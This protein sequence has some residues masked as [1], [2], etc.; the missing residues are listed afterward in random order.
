MPSSAEARALEDEIA[1][2]ICIRCDSKPRVPYREGVFVIACNCP[3]GPRLAKPGSE[4]ED[5]RGRMVAHHMEQDGH[6][7]DTALARRDRADLTAAAPPAMTVAEFHQRQGLIKAVVAEMEE[8]IHYGLIPGTHDKSLWE[9]GAE[10]LRAAFRIDWTFDITLAMEDRETHEYLYKVITRAI[11][12][13]G[14]T[15]AQ[16]AAQA[17]SKERRFWCKSECPKPCPQN[18]PPLGMEAEMMPHNVQD[19]SIKRGFVA[20]I[21]NVTGTTGYFKMALDE[22]ER[23]NS[24]PRATAS[25][26]YRCPEHDTDWFKKGKMRGYAHKLPDNT[27][28]NMPENGNGKAAEAAT[29]GTPTLNNP[30]DLLN[31]ALKRF[32]KESK[33]VCAALNVKEP[34]D[35]TDLRTA[36][37][38]LEMLWS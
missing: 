10:Y 14:Q 31:A 19:R 28:C 7:M 3:E 26:V 13:D 16:W 24:S 32:G 23:G 15:Y 5:R 9:P 27:W 1:G 18:H 35:I 11:Y 25:V 6:D 12:P 33:E 8:G 36:W 4:I 29:E 17:W 37:D 38:E 22:G 20:L 34:S 30:G 21:R 2:R